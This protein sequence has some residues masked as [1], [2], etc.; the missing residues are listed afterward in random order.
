MCNGEFALDKRLDHLR[1][2]LRPVAHGSPSEAQEQRL[3]ETDRELFHDFVVAGVRRELQDIVH[4]QTLEP[5]YS[6][7]GIEDFREKLE[8]GEDSALLKK[9]A[10]LTNELKDRLGRARWKL[11]HF[12]LNV[13][14]HWM[15]AIRLGGSLA[16]SQKPE[17]GMRELERLG[18][19]SALYEMPEAITEG[20]TVS[21]PKKAAYFDFSAPELLGADWSQ[22]YK[23]YNP[24]LED[25]NVYGSKMIRTY[26][27]SYLNK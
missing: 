5:V 15:H 9:I 14:H 27:T 8:K 12:T 20:E 11:K 7:M 10:A 25:K 1:R 23:E 18:H 17:D 19:E 24:S 26:E 16:M 13:V 4:W 6:E 21:D 22:K 2:A 3:H